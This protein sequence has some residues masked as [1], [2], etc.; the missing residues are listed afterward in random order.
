ME[1]RTYDRNGCVCSVL[2]LLSN[3]RLSGMSTETEVNAKKVRNIPQEM[4]PEQV[5]RIIKFIDSSQSET[6]KENIFS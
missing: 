3:S 1:R 5:K 2:S 4:N 6:I